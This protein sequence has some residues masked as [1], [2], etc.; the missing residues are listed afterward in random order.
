MLESLGR[1]SYDD[2]GATMISNVDAGGFCPNAW[3]DDVATS[4]CS[5][6]TTKDIVVHEFTHALTSHTAGLIYS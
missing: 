2:A 3:W 4:Y 5:G 6:M 1:N